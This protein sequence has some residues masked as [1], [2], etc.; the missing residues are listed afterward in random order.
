M[1]FT[2]LNFLIFFPIVLVIYYLLPKRVRWQFLLLASLFFYINI[3]PVFALLLVSVS[4]TTYI[5]A[6]LIEK[7]QSDKRRDN[8]LFIGIFLILLPLF[9]FKYY[10]AIDENIT[11]LLDKWHLRWSLPNISLLLPVGISFYTFM[12][13]GY[14]IDVYNEEIKA[15]KN[16]GL[17]TLFLSF[18]PLVLSGPIERAPSMLPQFKTKLDFNY[19]MAV[20]GFQMMLWGYFMKLVIADRLAIYLNP[21]FS[22]VDQQSGSTLFLST[23][24]YPIQVYGD[25]GGYSL[26][27]IGAASVM[28][29]KVRQ[30]FNRPFFATSMSEFWRRW[31]M[32]LINW[33]TDYLYTPLSLSF[34]KYGVFGIVLA[35]M[36]TFIIAGAWHGAAITFIFWGFV[37][38]IVLIKY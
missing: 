15:E 14:V 4:V 3:K 28:G 6:I 10:T 30:N 13:I 22:H 12:A 21:I 36:I 31:H 18:F 26:I 33:I 11:L 17:V 29:I 24:L 7:Q 8:L 37:Q 16:F 9:F 27:A 32:S 25:L 38:G 34:R 20:D 5:F 2:S 35:L 1:V 23:L 19:K